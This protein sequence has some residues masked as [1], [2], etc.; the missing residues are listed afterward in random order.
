MEETIEK[1]KN[2]TDVFSKA[3]LIRYLLIERGMKVIELA[4]K[5]SLT[6]P[7]ICHLNR[8]NEIPEAIVDGYYSK[9]VDIS[10]L[11]LLSR[12][13]DKKKMIEVYEKVLADDLTIRQTEELISE[14]VHQVKDKGSYLGLEEKNTLKEKLIKKY[15]DMKPSI[16][17]TRVKG[18]IEIE[19]RGN[20][21]ETSKKI[22]EIFNELSSV[23][24]SI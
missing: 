4:K 19:I 18:K 2:E 15:P 7:Y 1:I 10:H 16:N 12:I 21:E 8:L 5:L 11:F 22:K 13:K 3:K 17:Q 9:L 24:D 14:I 6:S 20:L 23:K